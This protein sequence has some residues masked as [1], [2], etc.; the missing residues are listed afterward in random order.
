M[1]LLGRTVHHGTSA[2][3]DTVKD[4]EACSEE[5][6]Q[7]LRCS[8]CVSCFSP[9]LCSLGRTHLA[10]KL[11]GEKARHFC[12]GLVVWLS[13]VVVYMFYDFVV[14]LRLSFDIA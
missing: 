2:S 9:P 1:S 12:F 6:E 3:I 5:R 7:W 10:G 11:L 8:R 14:K 13:I 4:D